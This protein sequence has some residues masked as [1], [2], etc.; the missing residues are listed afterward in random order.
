M[1]FKII[2]KTFTSA[3]QSLS[4]AIVG[5]GPGGFY[6]AKHLIKKYGDV[7]IDFYEKLPHPYGLVRTG[8]APDHQEVKNIE[9]DFKQLLEDSRVR[10]LGNVAVGHDLPLEILKKNIMKNYLIFQIILTI[11]K[12][13][14]L[15]KSFKKEMTL[16][17]IM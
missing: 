17:K 11:I 5:A 9:K 7:Q 13:H 12:I 4:F 2:K 16:L 10:F 15:K 14:N 3:N 6:T 1:N 8:V